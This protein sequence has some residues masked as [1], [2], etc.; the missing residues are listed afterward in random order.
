METF[1]GQKQIE[2]SIE[3][4]VRGDMEDIAR[5]ADAL[6]LDCT[7]LSYEQFM[8]ARRNGVILGFGR[9]KRYY[10]WSELATLGV[11]KEEQGKGIGTA[12]VCELLREKGTDVYVTCVIPKYFS[13]FGFYEVKEFPKLLMKKYDFCRSFGFAGDEVFVMRMR[14]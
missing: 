8:V 11:V 5:K 6:D 4:A 13:R 2:I 10:D 14:E 9:L 7:N 3:K 12:I 1:P